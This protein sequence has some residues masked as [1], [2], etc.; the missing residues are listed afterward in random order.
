LRVTLQCGA[1]RKSKSFNGGI[2][3]LVGARKQ[4]AA[5]RILQKEERQK[6]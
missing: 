5:S 1:R 6:Q 3:W 2:F 4:I